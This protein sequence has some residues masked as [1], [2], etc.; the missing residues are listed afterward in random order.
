MRPR[1]DTDHPTIAA[2]D[3]AIV[4]CSEYIGKHADGT[5]RVGWGW[6]AEAARVAVVLANCRKAV[7][8]SLTYGEPTPD[9]EEQ[10]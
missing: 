7:A 1:L 8:W 4:Q 6:C 10:G 2:L 9:T 3:K 5:H